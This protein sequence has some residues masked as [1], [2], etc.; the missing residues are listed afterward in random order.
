MGQTW[1]APSLARRIIALQRTVVKALFFVVAAV[2]SILTL[3]PPVSVPRD[4]FHCLL[5]LS[6]LSPMATLKHSQ[7]GFAMCFYSDHGA[8]L[9]TTHG[10]LASS[11]WRNVSSNPLPS[12]KRLVCLSVGEPEPSLR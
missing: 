1:A 5:P 10:P 3:E 11:L 8:S 2:F 12:L 4:L 6:L 9:T 7:G